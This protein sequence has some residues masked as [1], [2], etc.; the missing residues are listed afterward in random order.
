MGVRFLQAVGRPIWGVCA[1]SLQGVTH[2]GRSHLLS[3]LGSG[4]RG[5]CPRL[6]WGRTAS[7]PKYVEFRRPGSTVVIHSTLDH[8][9]GVPLGY[10][11][12]E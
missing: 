8:C 6:L 7:A 11:I 9:S 5:R 1:C 3:S 10:S 2:S 12:G 4:R